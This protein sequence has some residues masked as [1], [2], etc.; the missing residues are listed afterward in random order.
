MKYSIFWLFFLCSIATGETIRFNKHDFTYQISRQWEVEKRTNEEGDLTITLTRAPLK[1]KNQIEAIP[2]ITIML[3]R[4]FADP[5]N[6]EYDILMYTQTCLVFHAPPEVR[7]DFAASKKRNPIKYH[8]PVPN[9][10]AFNAPYKDDDNARHTNL[11]L[12]ALDP[13]KYG[14]FICIDATD[15]AFAKIEREI[16]DFL[17]SINT[18]DK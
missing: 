1:G 12:T 3:M 5:K 8:L 15:E 6:S 13:K 7:R 4:T 9:S 11:Y 16:I 10:Y 18:D 2:T 17:S 14:I